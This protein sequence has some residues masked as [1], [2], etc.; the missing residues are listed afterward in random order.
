M[1]TPTVTAQ[2]Q[3]GM[4]LTK[5]GNGNIEIDA[6]IW[7]TPETRAVD[8][9]ALEKVLP[10]FG[11]MREAKWGQMTKQVFSEHPGVKDSDK[12][13]LIF[14]RAMEV[15]KRDIGIKAAVLLA[16]IGKYGEH[17]S[18]LPEFFNWIHNKYRKTREKQQER[19]STFTKENTIGANSS[20]V[21]AIE[22]ALWEY[23]FQWEDI[24]IDTKIQNII[25]SVIRRDVNY[26]KVE[27]LM[28]RNPTNWK[29]YLQQEWSK[30]AAPAYQRQ[31]G[32]ARNWERGSLKNGHGRS[33]R[34]LNLEL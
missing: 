32:Y 34:P 3:A 1:S 23:D 2:G 16:K 26:I 11:T 30:Y 21:D 24:E 19:L 25:V 18:E 31:M 27:E 33:R 28:E 9:L 10:H 20:P 6:T 7:Q 4:G 14:G 13:R 22:E 15:G 12:L 17:S 8:L 29:S 5:L